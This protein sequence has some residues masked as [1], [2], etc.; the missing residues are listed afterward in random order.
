M[1]LDAVLP[2]TLKDAARA[3]LLLESLEQNFSGLR[4]IWV[5]CPDAQQ[6]E[7]A[8][9]YKTRRY[10]FELCVESE[11]A[12]AS[13]FALNLRQ[14]GWFRQ[15]MIKLAIYARIESELYLTLDADVVCT[16]SVSAEQLAGSGR[17]ACFVVQHHAQDYWYERNKCC[18]STPRDGV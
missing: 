10:A 6:A 1:W 2:L 17:G 15:Q 3:E 5:V 13:E 14:R 4:R 16:R 7:L 11:L 9:R 18:V 12:V 8:A